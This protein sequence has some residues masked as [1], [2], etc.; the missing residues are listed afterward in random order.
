M[1]LQNYI[2][3]C[4]QCKNKFKVPEL[5]GDP[6]GEFLLRNNAGNTLYLDAIS[7]FAFK[8]ISNIIKNNS[9]TK[10]M[11]DMSRA[12]VLHAIFGIACDLSSDK[13]EF[14]IGGNPIC[15]NC[16]SNE[17][18]SWEPIYPDEII[19]IN[20]P[21]VGHDQWNK[22]SDSEKQFRVNEAIEKFVKSKSDFGTF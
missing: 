12:S 3:Q 15:P 7:D 13:T 14:K 18:Y 20:V 19:D 4:G 21:K 1:K 16:H 5:L 22:L 6:Y 10:N 9:K 11:N 8:E 17:M 2:Y